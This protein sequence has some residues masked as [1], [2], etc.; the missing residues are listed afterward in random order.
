MYGLARSMATDYGQTSLAVSS[1]IY[2]RL[3]S[4]K[5]NPHSALATLSD[6][7]FRDEIS[8]QRKSRKEG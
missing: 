6:S 4:L 2:F 1:R 3:I 8:G 5:P 7:T